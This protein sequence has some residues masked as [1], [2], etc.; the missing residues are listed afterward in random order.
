M[1][2]IDNGNDPAVARRI[3]LHAA[4]HPRIFKPLFHKPDRHPE[5]PADG[6]RRGGVLNVEQP[7]HGY[8]EFLVKAVGF[9][10]EAYGTALFPDI[11][12]INRVVRMRTEGND[13]A[14]ARFRI[15]KHPAGV[16]RIGIDAG[17]AAGIEN[18]QLGG[19]IILK[20]RM[21]YRADMVAP[22]IREAGDRKIHPVNP[23]V[24]QSL[25]RHLHHKMGKPRRN[26]VFKVMDKLDSLRRCQ[27]RLLA[28]PPVVIVHR[29]E[30]RT[31]RRKI[32]VKDSLD[33]V[34]DR[35]FALCSGYPDNGK[36]VKAAPLRE[37]RQAHSPSY[38]GNGYVRKGR[39]VLLFADVSRRTE[40]FGIG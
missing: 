37:S 10:T 32:S 27:V 29:R 7:R 31:L 33:I 5:T 30:Y 4:L 22:D 11:R 6:N 16:F 19:K 40:S 8:P 35:A 18:F 15:L 28:Y 24:F 38:V 39:I 20:I 21:L 17:K 23:A 25:T 26:R 9:H 36:P 3:D 2:I 14:P 13:T 34:R 1:G 12:N